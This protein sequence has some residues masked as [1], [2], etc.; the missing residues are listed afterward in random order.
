MYSGV[1]QK[2]MIAQLVA[3]APGIKHCGHTVRLFCL[4]H[5]QFAQPCK[6]V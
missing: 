3:T 1:P 2:A 5:I 6:L 4:R